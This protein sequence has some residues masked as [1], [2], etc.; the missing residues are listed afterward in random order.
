MSETSS[1]AEAYI[2]PEEDIFRDAV[3]S[4]ERSEVD[5]E[6]YVSP[7][8][9]IPEHEKSDEQLDKESLSN[10]SE[11]MTAQDVLKD[12]AA[13]KFGGENAQV[14]TEYTGTPQVNELNEEDSIYK[15]VLYFDSANFLRDGK[16]VD[17]PKIQ[18]MA[19]HFRTNPD[20]PYMYDYTVVR[21]DGKYLCVGVLFLKDGMADQDNWEN[22]ET[23]YP[24]E[25]EVESTQSVEGESVAPPVIVEEQAYDTETDFG[26]ELE[27]SETAMEAVA[28]AEISVEIDAEESIEQ[29]VEETI[30][31][32]V[33]AEEVIGQEAESVIEISEAVSNETIDMGKAASEI[34]ERV[35][36]YTEVIKSL[37]YTTSHESELAWIDS[38]ISNRTLAAESGP[39]KVFVPTAPEAPVAPSVIIEESIPVRSENSGEISMPDVVK[40]I[41]EIIIPEQEKL[42]ASIVS[43]VEISEIVAPV[44]KREIIG[45]VK[46]SVE[47]S[48]ESPAKIEIQPEVPVVENVLEQKVEVEFKDA[49]KIPAATVEVKIIQV[50]EVKPIVQVK[51]SG[52]SE[53]QEQ[54]ADVILTEALKEIFAEPLVREVAP[55][56]TVLKVGPIKV[57][58]VVSPVEVIVKDRAQKDVE[59]PSATLEVVQ[60]TSSEEIT[61][62]V[63]SLEEREVITNER[64]ASILRQIGIQ[65]SVESERQEIG[66]AQTQTQPSE[67]F[68]RVIGNQT[69]DSDEQENESVAPQA[70]NDNSLNGIRLTRNAA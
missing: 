2:I 43:E 40:D 63:P 17:D 36:S 49:E 26:S 59:V 15:G 1:Y 52:Q 65:S 22:F 3:S 7:E 55:S 60:Q 69:Q 21:S 56:N 9:D 42:V 23:K 62:T 34:V 28:E 44:Q 6:K 64:A 30:S 68:R 53:Q 38:K 13:N 70:A 31:E 67:N 20:K 58:S 66:L 16:I 37:V 39:E 50:E 41:Q 5:P 14:W 47:E 19:E 33:V 4:K 25:N 48:K 61:E 29:N 54:N 11:P 46:D 45:E 8:F 10:E 32:I 27:I 18:G 57:E 12:I 51:Q 24:D 35:Q